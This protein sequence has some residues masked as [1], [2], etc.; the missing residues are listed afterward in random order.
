MEKNISIVLYLLIFYS[1]TIVSCRKCITCTE[2]KSGYTTEYCG[3]NTQVK[4]FEK[5][6]IE[7]GKIVGQ[8]WICIDK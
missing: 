6:L 8:S 7:T 4:T 1:F 2:K 5:E 3:T